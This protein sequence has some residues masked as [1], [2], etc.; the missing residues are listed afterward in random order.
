VGMFLV[1]M[2]ARVAPEQ[3]EQ[4]IRAFDHVKNRRPPGVVQSLLARDAHDQAIWRVL[5]FWESHEAL[6]AHFQSGALMPS[7]YIFHLI[8]QTPISVASTI[9]ATDGAVS[10][11]PQPGQGNPHGAVG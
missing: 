10:A 2:E 6:E 11:P 1:M 4:L 7:A 8:E 3:E 9:I 5:T